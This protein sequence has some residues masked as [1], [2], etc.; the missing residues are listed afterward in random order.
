MFDHD[1]GC[2]QQSCCHIHLCC[3]INL[4]FTA[5]MILTTVMIHDTQR[6]P[7]GDDD[8]ISTYTD[9]STFTICI[10]GIYSWHFFHRWASS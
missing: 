10:Q 3:H 1:C 6:W 2:V 8:P 7:P 9:L 5:V 4:T